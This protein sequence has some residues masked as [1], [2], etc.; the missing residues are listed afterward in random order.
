MKSIV[1]LE[2]TTHALTSHHFGH[3][4]GPRINDIGQLIDCDGG[5]RNWTKS[6][7]NFYIHHYQIRSYTDFLQ[8]QTRGDVLFGGASGYYSSYF[9]ELDSEAIYEDKTAIELW[10]VI[11]NNDYKKLF[12][13]KEYLEQNP[14]IIPLIEKG[15]FTCAGIIGY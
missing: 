14:H 11:K 15:E 5:G 8:K 6:Y 1:K 13:E 10:E 12:V 9:Q 7:A 2:K 3:V 4:D